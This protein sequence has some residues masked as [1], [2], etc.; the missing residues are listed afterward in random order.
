MMDG[1]PTLPELDRNLANVKVDKVL[2]LM[3]DKRTE[4]TAHDAVPGRIVLL[5]ELLLD[6][7]RNVL[8]DVEAVDGLGCNIDCI[9]LHFVRHIHI[10]DDG[11]AVLSH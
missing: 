4:G 2:C 6:V 1:L 3:H 8:L 11:A 7:R 5:I 9:S 10:L